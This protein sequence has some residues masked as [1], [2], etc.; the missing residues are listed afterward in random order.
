MTEAEW[1][2]SERPGVMLNHL[3]HGRAAR[4]VGTVRRHRLFAVACCRQGWHLLA[5]YPEVRAC[6]EFAEA[7]ADGTAPD[8]LRGKV[9]GDCY[10]WSAR[11]QKST[12]QKSPFGDTHSVHGFARVAR[13]V[14]R[15]E[16]AGGWGIDDV[17]RALSADGSCICPT[18]AALLRCIFGNPFRPVTFAPAW[19]TET[20]V[21]LAAGIY[22]ERAFDRLPILADALEEAGCDHAEV[23]AHCRGPGP[24]VRGCWV[25]DAVLGKQ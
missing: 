4:P 8:E 1:L 21:A 19:R 14:C 9:V 18:P 23:L 16:Y 10:R 17:L 7:D 3:T 2:Q 6:L 12:R 5:E 15:P 13:D 25:V 22:A 20:V 24:H 11:Q